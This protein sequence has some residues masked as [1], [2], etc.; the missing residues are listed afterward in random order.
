MQDFDYSKSGYLGIDDFFNLYHSLAYVRSVSDRQCLIPSLSS[1][2]GMES[3]N[4][5][6]VVESIGEP[7]I[8]VECSASVVYC[9]M[10]TELSG[11]SLS[12]SLHDH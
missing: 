10:L 1:K 11:F 3:G 4:E 6:R 8:S 9:T 7:P 12:T 2:C 5:T